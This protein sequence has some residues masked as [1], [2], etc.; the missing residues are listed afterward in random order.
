MSHWTKI[1][2]KID[3]ET[4]IIKAANELGYLVKKNSICRG[5]QGNTTKCDLVLVLPGEYDLG[6]IKNENTGEYEIIADFWQ[7]HLSQYLGNEKL[8]NKATN[9]EEKNIA[10]IAKFM[11]KYSIART[12]EILLEQGLSYIMHET[13]EGEVV[14]EVEEVF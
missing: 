2:V 14:F 1:K 6:F 8:I 10:K 5:Y 11:Q 7:N 4:A 13:P 12:E 9:E 3:S